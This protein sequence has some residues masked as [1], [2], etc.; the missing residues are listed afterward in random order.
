VARNISDDNITDQALLELYHLW[1]HGN[2][3]KKDLERTYW[4]DTSSN[5]KRFSRLMLERHGI[6]TEGE[7]PKA[8]EARILRSVL[9]EEGYDVDAILKEAE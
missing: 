7:H 6:D 5:G 2:R 9:E 4:N 3:S 1:L 8:R